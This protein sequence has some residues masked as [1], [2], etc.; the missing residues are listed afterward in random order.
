VTYIEGSETTYQFEALGRRTETRAIV[1]HWTGGEGGGQQVFQTLRQRNLSVHFLI[2]QEGTI[3]QYA[4][5]G[6]RC[7]HAGIANGWS[8]GIEIA[9]RANE[10]EA[11]KLWHR[12]LVET[13]IHGRKV[14]YTNFLSAQYLSC[15]WLVRKVCMHYGLPMEAPRDANG[16]LET[17]VLGV[18]RL[19]T[20]RGVLGHYHLTAQKTDPG[21][22][23]LDFLTSNAS[24]P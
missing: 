5:L 19:R 8:I 10:Q 23:I 3:F 17:G 9:N 18:D 11:H 16:V 14:T 22:E 1:V 4:P 21:P 2:D 7:S 6:A 12:D 13:K 24:A 20:F 15:Y